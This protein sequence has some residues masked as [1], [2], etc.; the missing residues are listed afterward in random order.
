MPQAEPLR[1]GDPAG[2]GPYRFV[3]R[4][5]AGGQGVVYLGQ[6]PD[7]RPVAIKVLREDV[8]GDDRFAKEI[9][10]ARRV[11][12]F[13]IAQVLDASLG[14]RPYIVTEYVEGPSLQQAGRHFGADLQRLA[15]ATA[16]ALAAIHRA[17]VVHRDFKPDNVL[18]GRDGPRVIDF[19]I[20]RTLGASVTVTSSVVGTPSYMAPEQVLGQTVG[21]PTDVFAWALV[22][23]FAATGTPPFGNDSIPAVINRVLY[24]NPPLADLPEPLR[25]IVHGCLAKD[26]AHRPAMQDVLF[27]LIGGHAPPPPPPPPPPSPSRTGRKTAPRNRR[28]A[29]LAATGALGVSAAVATAVLVWSADTP[30]PS[31]TS[32]AVA[33]P[34]GV[35]SL[36]PKEPTPGKERTPAKEKAKQSEKPPRDRPT[37]T[38]DETATKPTADPTSTPAKQTAK[39]TPSTKPTET[40]EPTT[41]TGGVGSVSITKEAIAQGDCLRHDLALYGH[42]PGT[43]KGTEV[44]YRWVINGADK[45]RVV[46][47]TPAKAI[48]GPPDFPKGGVYRV[49][50]RVI[51]PVSVQRSVTVKVCDPGFD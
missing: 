6:A 51:T 24:E 35:G 22:I 20:A 13:C 3:G 9:A 37:R 36:T 40:D 44:S 33:L 38:P 39:A 10:A 27:Q 49:V 50:L 16:T 17:G 31:S 25:S 21:P 7:G 2:V 11:E 28:N 8:T 41:A 46:A 30:Q 23:V 29:V 32:S 34:S 26:P 5:G 19:G 48:L 15:V 43:R 42:I 1:A 45:P 18:L 14:G 12:P 47:T 4:L